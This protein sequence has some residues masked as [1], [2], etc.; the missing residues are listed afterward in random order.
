MDTD[1]KPITISCQD[2]RYLHKTKESQWLL[3]PII[4]KVYPFWA[5]ARTQINVVSGLGFKTCKSMFYKL[6]ASSLSQINKLK[7]TGN[8]SK[9]HRKF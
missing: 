9:N 1:S 8:H 6:Q 7:I 2:F 3:Y 4:S 5:Y